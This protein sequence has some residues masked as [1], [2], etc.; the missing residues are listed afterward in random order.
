MYRNFRKCQGFYN[1]RT[2]SLDEILPWDILDCGV[3]KEFLKREWENALQEKVSPNCRDKCNGCGAMKYG[4]GVCVADRS[5]YNDEE[6]IAKTG[7]VL[8]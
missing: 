4:C 5:I 1:T 6:T 2:R 8:A 7:E 3:S